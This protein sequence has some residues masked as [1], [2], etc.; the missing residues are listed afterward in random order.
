MAT[1]Y[2]VLVNTIDSIGALC[3][4]VCVSDVTV[5]AAFAFSSSDPHSI[6]PLLPPSTHLKTDRSS[7]TKERLHCHGDYLSTEHTHTHGRSSAAESRKRLQSLQAGISTPPTP[8]N[9]THFARFNVQHNS[10]R[11]AASA[12]ASTKREKEGEGALL[13]L[14]LLLL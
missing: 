8:A 10:T 14:L 1:R 2:P 6:C 3:G 13:L 5:A 4:R 7:T 12:K 11:I 9:S